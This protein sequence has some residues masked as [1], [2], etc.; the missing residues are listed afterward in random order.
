MGKNSGKTVI[1]SMSGYRTIHSKIEEELDRLIKMSRDIHG[2]P[3]V[4][5]EEY[6]AS[7]L[8]TAY[9]KEM[10]FKV[11]RGVGGLKTAF[12]ATYGE[13]GYHIG[14]CSEYDALPEI[15]HGCGHNLIAI[16]AVA[17]GV[18][19][20]AAL[21]GRPG[22]VSV[23]GTPDE[24][25]HGGKVDLVR[26]GVF[27]DINAAMMFHPSCSTRINVT[28]LACCDYRFIFHGKNAHAAIEPWEGRNALDAVIQT[29]NGINALRQHLKEDVRVHGIITEGGLAT[30]VIPDRSVAEFLVRARDSV[31]LEEAVEKVTACARGAATATGTTLEIEQSDYPYEAMCSNNV[32][33]DVFAESL[34]QAGYTVQSAQTGEVG[35]I[36][37][38]NVSRVTPSIYPLLALTDQWVPR[39]TP[40]FAALCN[41][42]KAYDVM[43]AAGRAMAITGLKVFDSPV[44]QE[45]IK[46]EF[47][48]LKQN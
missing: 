8:I 11:W 29:F 41:T 31:G 17:A 47:S 48:N 28:S 7:D 25:D 34:P 21:E 43:L 46:E 15:G 5:G 24:E 14:F 1:K 23:I 45:K 22:R 4:G 19:L 3:E 16:A 30:N 12:M 37:M 18:A 40:E 26:T 42:E 20:A 27:D 36:D 10:G 9:L 32:L 13:E 35:S 44:L 38:G 39:H 33:A 6:F 2:H